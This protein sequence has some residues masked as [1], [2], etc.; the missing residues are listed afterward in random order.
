[1]V[2]RVNKRKKQKKVKGTWKKAKQ[3]EGMIILS[4][5]EEEGEA[6]WMGKEEP[7][8]ENVYGATERVYKWHQL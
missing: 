2:G 6:R 1:M 8:Q 5:D 7:S 3:V 4:S